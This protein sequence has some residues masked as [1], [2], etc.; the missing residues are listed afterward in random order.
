MNLPSNPRASRRDFLVGATVLAAA[1]AGAVL[2]EETQADFLFVQTAKGMSFDK[3]AGRLTLTGVSPVTLFF[4][5]R[6]ERIAGNMSTG[7]F[8]PFWSE[9]PDSF[10]SDPP[11]ADVSIVEGGSLRQTVVVLKDPELSGEDLSYTVEVIQGEMPESGA[12]V[13]VFI[14]IIG[15]PLTPVSF[16]GADRRAF[17]RAAIY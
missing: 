17:R 1:P 12:E 6:P 8:V 2:A 3:G 16:A 13:S 4:T 5:D 9:G 15:R 14:D 10:Q 11:N 7:K